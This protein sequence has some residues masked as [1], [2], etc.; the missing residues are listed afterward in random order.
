MEITILVKAKLNLTIKR[1][2]LV[3]MES[4]FVSE[5]NNL[6]EEKINLVGEEIIFAP[7]PIVRTR[8]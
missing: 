4:I 2:N 5:K 1:F 8:P 7:M 3:K 6:V